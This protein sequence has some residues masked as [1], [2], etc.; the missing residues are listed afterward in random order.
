MDALSQLHSK[1]ELHNR[2]LVKCGYSPGTYPEYLRRCGAQVGK[3]CSIAPLNK[4]VGIDARLLK[5]GNHVEIAR[6]VVFITHDGAA[7]ALRHRVP[8]VPVFSPIVVE[9]NCFIGCGAILCPGIRIGRKSVVAP[10]SVVISDVPPG[11]IVRGAP[12]RIVAPTQIPLSS[13]LP[14]T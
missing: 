4:D 3:N 11:V 13:D 5:I 9:D 12:A 7:R 6:E 14:I 8:G 2:D 10:S 1:Y